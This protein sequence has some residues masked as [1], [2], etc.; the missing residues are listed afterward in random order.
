[1]DEPL[2][3]IVVPVY[4]V[5]KY[6]RKNFDTLKKQTYKNIEILFIDDGSTDSSGD[7]CELFKKEDKRVKVIHKKNEG[8]G[9]ARNTGI[10]SANGKYIMFIDS[11]DFVHIEMV[12][13]LMKNLL[14]T[15]SDTSYCGYFEYYNE[16]KIINKP[17][18]YN[19]RTFE[20]EEI[21]NNI[22]L[23][24]IASNPSEKN[25][26]LLSMS[27]WHAVYS[28]DIIK[29]NNI[30]FPSEREYISED[31]IFDI[32]YLTKSKKI[33]YIS[34]QLYYYRCNNNNSLTH[35]YSIN[36]FEMHKK[37]VDKINEELSKILDIKVYINRTDRYLLG[38]LR[39]CIQKATSYKEDNKNFKLRMHIKKLIN[40][41]QISKILE[42]YPYYQNPLIQR[43]FNFFVKEK[44]VIGLIILVKFNNIRKNKRF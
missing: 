33:S 36:E 44:F 32:K 38:R 24:M 28:I 39:T 9:Y 17:A 16:D 10:E 4:N 3:S 41:E 35:R 13:K 8:L 6:L 26:S 40:D 14:E 34:D 15:N 18:F 22:L 37:V 31:I 43:I 20:K 19:N 5:S 30:F 21:I 29:K 12:E 27:V 25:D 11:D 1:M 7:L 23:N 2:V 42:R